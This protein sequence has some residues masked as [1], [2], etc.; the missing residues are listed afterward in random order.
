MSRITRAALNSAANAAPLDTVRPGATRRYRRTVR[1]TI[2]TGGV[3]QR[4]EVLSDTVL[5]VG[6]AAREFEATT[7]FAPETATL[8]SGPD[9]LVLRLPVARRV[10]RVLLNVVVLNDEVA[11]FR[12]DG[13]AVS[14]DA[15]ASAP[16]GDDG[17]AL[18]VTD[19]QLILRRRRAG[20]DETLAPGAVDGVFVAVE[21]VQPRVSFAIVGDPDGE[22][23]LPPAL[24]A[25]GAPILASNDTWGPRLA[26]AL[27]A[28]LARFAAG[29]TALPNPV[30]VDL[31]LEADTPCSAAI[32]AFDFG[33]VLERIGFS[34][35]T[36]R[37]VLRFAAGRGETRAVSLD[38]PPGIVALDAT[39]RLTLAGSTAPTVQ[40]QAAVVAGSAP[41]ATVSHGVTVAPG[42][43]AATPLML[44]GATVVTGADIVLG[45]IEVPAEITVGLWEE[46]DGLPGQR[47]AESGP[48]MLS[49]ARPACVLATFSPGVT[50]P[51]AR[52][53]VAIS[54]RRGRV[55]LAL[56]PAAEGTVVAGD[57]KTWSA[58]PAAVGF[59]GSVRLRMPV[60][61][62]D[63]GIVA[64]GPVV[65]I[66]GASLPVATDGRT[67]VAVFTDRLNALPIPRP[68]QVELN[69]RAD[70]GGVVTVEAPVLRYALT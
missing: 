31:I 25:L 38:L 45:A 61:E 42:R 18:N 27:T 22:V 44:T 46:T 63:D 19:S 34:D 12:F 67:Q 56:A 39:M 3:A 60:P 30:L 43:L 49:V 9:G 35:G 13:R 41:P 47:L 5:N 50:L 2:P 1:V 4:M 36:D 11:A 26:S 28:Q 17:A 70:S 21:P 55:F 23:T 29:R 64:Q 37:Q 59:V 48:V 6:F 24:D 20:A 54:A 69:I 14:D 40:R 16:H 33:Y 66:G 7:P 8:V 52:V 68:S 15:V 65:S 51:A 10:S 57:G 32:N 62:G 58:L 53:W